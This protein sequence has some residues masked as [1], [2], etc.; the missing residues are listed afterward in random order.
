MADVREYVSG[1]DIRHLDR[2]START[3][4]LHVRSFQEER[5]RVTLLVADFRPAMLWG[6]KRAFR[7]VAA[8]EALVLIGWQAVEQGGRVGLL[9]LN[10]G[11]PVAVPARG[12]T[13]GMLAAIGGMVRA[14]ATALQQALDGVQTD[15]PLSNALTRLSRLA[16]KGAEIVIA[17]GFDAPGDGLEDCLGELSHRRTPRLIQIGDTGST[18]LPAGAYPMRL[19]DGTRRRVRISGLRQNPIAQPHIANL[20]VLPLDAG[21]EVQEFARQISADQWGSHG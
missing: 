10:A 13:K 7:S 8:A 3:G 12:R 6:S 14:H 5:D 20:P 19:F 4:T 17:S 11:I 2:G 15:P 1:D 21:Q 9:A 16:P 18:D